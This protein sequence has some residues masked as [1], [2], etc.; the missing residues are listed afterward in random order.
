MFVAPAAFCVV[1]VVI[2]RTAYAMACAVIH[3]RTVPTFQA[4]TRSDNFTG[5]GNVPAF[6]LRHKVGALNGR[7]AGVS[8][9]FGLWTNCASRIY[10]LSGSE[11]KTD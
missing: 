6:T 8:G 1:L 9:L 4:V 2:V 5:L 3:A 10:A 11:S 7:G